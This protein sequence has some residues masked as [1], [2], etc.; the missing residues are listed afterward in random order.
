MRREHR[1]RSQQCEGL[2][3]VE[4]NCI[5]TKHSNFF[6]ICFIKVHILAFYFYLTNNNV[7]KFNYCVF[8]IH[9]QC[10]VLKLNAHHDKFEPCLLVEVIFLF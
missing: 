3:R 6:I 10:L 2:S 4:I 7:A 9:F 5:Y 1:W 8:V